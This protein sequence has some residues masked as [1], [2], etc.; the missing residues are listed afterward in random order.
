M[1]KK[2][3]LV[4]LRAIIKECDRIKKIYPNLLSHNNIGKGISF[5]QNGEH[6]YQT[7]NVSNENSHEI[8]KVTFNVYGDTNISI[9]SKYLSQRSFNAVVKRLKKITRDEAL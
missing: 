7:I 3:G 9:D 6:T 2:D 5:Y 8:V 1:S 4:D